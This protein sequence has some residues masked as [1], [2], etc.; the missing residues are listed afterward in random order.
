MAFTIEKLIQAL[1]NAA[2]DSE[3]GLETPIIFQAITSNED[4]SDVLTTIE[5][6]SLGI[7]GYLEGQ[8]LQFEFL[9]NDD[10]LNRLNW[11]K[12]GCP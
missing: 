12:K 11:S 5:F 7:V 2:E 1:Q 8:F 3:Q 6:G 9:I 4:V 10:A